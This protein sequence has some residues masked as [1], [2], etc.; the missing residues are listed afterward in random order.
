MTS[1]NANKNTLPDDPKSYWLDSV[2]IAAYPPLEKDIETEVAVVGGGISG[3]TTAFLLA[4]EGFQVTLLESTRLFNGTTGH[5]TAKVTAQHG[6]I[7][8]E[9]IG[10]F[11][12]DS[13]KLYYSANKDA[14]DFIENYINQHGIDCDYQKESAYVFST[15]ESD[16][17][18]LEKEAKAYEKIGV[19][20]GFV[21]E[22]PLPIPVIGAVEMKNQAQ[23]H[24]LK[25]LAH[26]VKEMT[27]QGV[28]IFEGM[29]AINMEHGD[30]AVVHMR[31][32]IK[33]KAK[34]VVSA[35]HFPFHDGKGYFARLYPK[36]SYV[37]AVKPEQ[38]FPNGMYISSNKPTRSFRSVKINGEDMLLV[39]G[40]SHKTGQGVPE[41]DHYEALEKDAAKLF[42]AKKVLYRW[43]AQ[44]L[45]TPDKVP[46]IG[47]ISEN[48]SNVFIA[49]GFRK[50]GMAHGTLSGMLISDLITGRDNP[51]EKL[52]APSRFPLDPS[53]KTL[54]KEN[55]N[56][57]AQ[58]IGGK[59]ERPDK[60]IKDIR[61]D[62]GAVI[63]IKGKRAGAYK[64]HNGELFV[65]DT[66][67]THM[68]CEVN[69]NSGDKTWDCPCHGSRFGYDG[70]V[71]EG[72]AD[73]P[74]KRID[75]D[76]IDYSTST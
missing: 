35:S 67:C 38:S 16:R 50:W 45:V 25:Y 69:W 17:Q 58:L 51:Y 8:D 14:A 34:F 15:E 65:V 36:R 5:T 40:E 72:P 63:T 52:Y 29:T 26:M 27:R 56:V 42:G 18:S 49:T 43:S 1:E 47:R 59:F 28:Q 33:V 37:V 2:D 39:I 57:A 54:V 24:P 76:R 31:N 44:D 55:M 71:I 9:L 68:G 53:F 41:I 61:Q 11:G 22:I 30:P 64:D 10:N 46:Y 23:F 19:N 4:K 6:L 75:P 3:I 70:K 66:T 7:Y 48:H 13:V 32:G 74:L 20:G 60:E 62:E 73:Q 21:D 12:V